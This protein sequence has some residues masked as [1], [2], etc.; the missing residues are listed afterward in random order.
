MVCPL[1][2]GAR[3]VTRVQ[4]GNALIAHITPPDAPG[5]CR[6][7]W[8]AAPAE[9]DSTARADLIVRGI[10]RAGQS[11]YRVRI[12]E[13]RV[14]IRACTTSTPEGITHRVG[15][16]HPVDFPVA[17]QY[18]PIGDGFTGHGVDDVALYGI[19]LGTDVIDPPKTA[20]SRPASG[21]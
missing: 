5:R 6:H 19:G 3:T 20:A 9:T 13:P 16:T 1:A 8:P 15:R 4:G 2:I 14:T 7:Q 17:Y 18:D 21:R 11:H 12:D 10:Q